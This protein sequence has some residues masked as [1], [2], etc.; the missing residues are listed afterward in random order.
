MEPV[1]MGNEILTIDADTRTIEV[2][3]DFLL[4]VETDNDAERVEFQCPK[5]VGDNLDLTQYH[6]YIHYQNAK[7]D[8]GKYLCEDIQDS[9]ENITFSWLLSNKVTLY[10]GQTKF[11]VCAKKTQ[12]ETIVWNTTLASGNVL[13]GLDVDEDIVQQNDDVIEQI[14]LRLERIE[15]SGGTGLTQ[16]QITALDNMFKICSYTVDPTSHYS[17]FCEAFGIEYA[18]PSEDSYTITNNLT[19]ATNSNPATYIADG[20]SYN[21]TISAK[22]GYTLNSVIIE[23]GGI[24]ITETSYSDGTISISNVTG[25]IVITVIAIATSIEAELPTDGLL[26]YFDLRNKSYTTGSGG[27]YYINSDFGNGMLYSW[28][29]QSSKQGDNIGLQ[30]AAGNYTT[31]RAAGYPVTDNFPSTR[32]VCLFGKGGPSV[33]ND[34]GHDGTLNNS[35]LYDIK[36][37]ATDGTT[38]IVLPREQIQYPDGFIKNDY[39]ASFVVVNQN[40]LKVYFDNTLHKTVDGSDIEDFKSWDLANLAVTSFNTYGTAYAF[41]NK[42]LSEVEINEALAFF[43]T[44]EVNE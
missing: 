44:L 20:S 42:E 15:D 2:P 40:I 1:L 7:G 16:A 21:A 8:K 36:Y 30:G 18:P 12:E 9:G 23:M 39:N 31:E 26:D 22:Q 6:I 19:N 3:S 10:K 24:D 29:N 37:K 14:L 33:P 4:G 38:K 5:V 13:E 17:A 43:H 27:L 34:I 11:L 25:N 28:S 35:F 32:T 41:Y